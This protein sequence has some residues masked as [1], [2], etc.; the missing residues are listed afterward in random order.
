LVGFLLDRFGRESTIIIFNLQT[1]FSV[2]STMEMAGKE[3]AENLY[4]G[5]PNRIIWTFAA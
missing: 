5:C 3:G 1:F 4:G 2:E